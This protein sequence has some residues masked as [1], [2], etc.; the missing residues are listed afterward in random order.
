[1]P[2]SQ[3][4]CLCRIESFEVQL[5]NETTTNSLYGKRPRIFAPTSQT[6][7]PRPCYTL[8]LTCLA[9]DSSTG[10]IHGTVFDPAIRRIAGAGVALVNTATENFRKAGKIPES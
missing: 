4:Q 10:S 1:M 5:K 9:E 3:A 8:A 6:S 7:P 2:E